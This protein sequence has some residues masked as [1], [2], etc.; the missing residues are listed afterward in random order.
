MYSVML[1]YVMY[2]CM[3]AYVYIYIYIHMY[4]YIYIYTYVCLAM[5]LPEAVV[6]AALHGVGFRLLLLIA[7]TNNSY[8]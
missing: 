8:Y 7:T 6:L 1:C 5:P 4:V 3:Y 2:V